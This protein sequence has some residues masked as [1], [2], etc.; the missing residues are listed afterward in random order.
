VPAVISNLNTYLAIATDALTKA[1]ELEA[2]QT[3]PMPDGHAGK[4]MMWDPSRASFKHSLIAIVFAGVYLDALLYIADRKQPGQKSGAKAAKLR[5]KERGSNRYLVGLA[6]IGIT[7]P[8]IVAACQRLNEVRDG[9]VHER[10]LEIGPDSVGE[11]L[12]VAQREA[13]HALAT[14][15]RVSQALGVEN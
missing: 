6:K 9:I 12:H 13:E 15:N 10:A 8:E 1:Q 2:A 3:R 14:V 5:R 7:D 11:K 4:I